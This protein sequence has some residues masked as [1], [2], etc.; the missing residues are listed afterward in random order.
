MS[1]VTLCSAK[2]SPGVTTLTCVLGAVWPSDRAVV[3]AECD[4]SG[5]DLA[6]RF[7]L[8]ARLGMTSLV[9]AERQRVEQTSDWRKHLQQL[10][11][12][13][14]VLVAPAGADSAM[15][16][17]HELGMSSSVLA[18]GDWDL[19]ADCGRLLPGAVGQERMIRTADVVLVLVRPD[20]AGVAHARWAT[21]RIGE[22]SSFPPSVVIVGTGVFTPA[23]V[24]EELDVNVLG[25]A[26]FDPR[27]ASMAAGAPGTAREF[28]RSGLVGFAREIVSSLTESAPVDASSIHGTGRRRPRHQDGAGRYRIRERRSPVPRP[29]TMPPVRT[30]ERPRTTSA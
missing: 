15:A 1:R 4:P 28:V 20:V 26:P 3:V 7:G 5:G 30:D 9:L 11:G 6:G 23:E 18:P 16:L 22:L 2:G 25:T 27:A 29:S 12:G 21:S 10:P 14:D 13:L 17:D 19:L 8:S 24:G